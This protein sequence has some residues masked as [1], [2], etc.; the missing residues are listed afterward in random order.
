MFTD[1]GYDWLSSRNESFSIAHNA[2]HE[3]RTTVARHLL[4]RERL[5]DSLIFAGPDGRRC[6]EA[7]DHIWELSMRR[8][9][10]AMAHYVGPTL[11]LCLS[12][13]EAALGDRE[14]T[15]PEDHRHQAIRAA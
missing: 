8:A 2:H 3:S 12:A 14:W 9:D 7:G 6:C 5:G 13:A 15:G 11:P 1:V 4:H 10:G